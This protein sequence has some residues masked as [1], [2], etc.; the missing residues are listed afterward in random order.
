M[1]I[2]LRDRVHTGLTVRLRC[3]SAKVELTTDLVIIPARVTDVVREGRQDVRV[4]VVRM[5]SVC[6]IVRINCV[7][8]T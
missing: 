8:C 7:V 1:H 2:L 5:R 6:E 3:Q 4:E